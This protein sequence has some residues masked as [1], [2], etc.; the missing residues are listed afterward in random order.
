LRNPPTVAQQHN[1]FFNVCLAARPVGYGTKA[2]IKGSVDQ[3]VDQGVSVVENVHLIDSSGVREMLR[4]SGPRRVIGDRRDD[5]GRPL[6][7]P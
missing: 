2:A 6:F 1:A 3:G 5:L 4:S 7:V